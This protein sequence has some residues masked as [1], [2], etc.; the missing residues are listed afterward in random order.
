MYAIVIA[1]IIYG[2]SVF[3]AYFQFKQFLSSNGLPTDADQ[4]TQAALAKLISSYNHGNDTAL[5]QLDPIQLRF[6][7]CG[8]ND[9]AD[10]TL[11][12]PLSCCPSSSSAAAAAHLCQRTQAYAHGCYDALSNK[13]VALLV[14]LV[15]VCI[16]LA[17]I[18]ALT[19]T[20]I[21]RVSQVLRQ[22]NA[23]SS[24]QS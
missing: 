1:I 12:L 17:I 20:L 19:L 6:G 15:S 4:D 18:P 11:Q 10:Y 16:F 21:Y 2:V 24:S 23:A 22:F 14:N 8:A 5:R 7:C 9:A 13:Q 3:Y